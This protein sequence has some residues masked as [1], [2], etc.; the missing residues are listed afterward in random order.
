MKDPGVSLPGQTPIDSDEKQGLIPQHIKS[1]SELNEF[2]E[3]NIREAADR[4]LSGHRRH[5]LDDPEFLKH[6]HKEM[7]GQ[8]WRWAGHY[9]KSDK[10]LG[11]PWV[12]IPE[13]MKKACDDFRHWLENRTYDA[14]EIAVRFHHRL[15]SIHPFPNG[16]GRHAR[17]AADIFLHDRNHKLLTW[18]GTELF[19]PE[20]GR[21][22]YIDGL[23]KADKGDFE[24][25]IRFA[26]S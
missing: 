11:K 24:H 19:R 16:N 23:K 25:L 13:E 18:G 7:F 3:M 12:M 20:E 8:T 22:V 21:K 10:N 4:Y 17:L 1:I 26:A 5:H 9:R 6:V 15:V 14:V 2:E